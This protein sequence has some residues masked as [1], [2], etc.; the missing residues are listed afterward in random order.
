MNFVFLYASA[1]NPVHF[2]KNIV[3]GLYNFHP[4]PTFSHFC[5]HLLPPEKVEAGSPPEAG[6]PLKT[7]VSLFQQEL[8]LRM[9]LLRSAIKPN[10]KSITGESI[11]FFLSLFHPYN[12]LN[13]LYSEGFTPTVFK[14]TLL[15][16]RELGYPTLSPTS[17]TDI[18]RSFN[19]SFAREILTSAK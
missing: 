2:E 19:N 4:V 8:I 15:K 12:L 11:S 3:G 7:E 10:C 14:N 18:L 17:A 13:F 9:L 16:Y 5:P 6:E 1:E